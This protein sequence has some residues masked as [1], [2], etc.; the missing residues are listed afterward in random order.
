[1]RLD[2]SDFDA[3]GYQM[4]DVRA[5][6]REWVPTYEDTVEDAMD[7]AL[8][9]DLSGPA[10]D[11]VR[12]AAD[13]GCGTGRTGAWL[14][15]HG[16]AAI[17]GVDLTPEM[18][19]VARERGAHDRLV[20]ADVADS[21]LDDGAYDLVIASLVDEHLEDLA[22]LYREAWRL[23]EPGAWLVLVAFH[24][25]FIMATGMPTHFTTASGEPLAIATHVHLLS[26]HVTAGLQAG[27][28]LAE[29]REGVIDDRWLAVKPKWE[30]LRHHPVSAAFAWRRPA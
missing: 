4:V 18:L 24:P 2:F 25:H 22:P 5:G 26:D 14:R 9:D 12:R 19:E 23:A 11:R 27:W 15:E 16:V 8:L 17:D 10:W 28:T 30:H 13:L 6:Y 21:G 29:M 7:I 3:R 1:V 20:E